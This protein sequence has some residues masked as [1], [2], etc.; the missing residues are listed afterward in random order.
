MVLEEI[1]K[2]REE[3]KTSSI[4][5]ESNE[6]LKP[7]DCVLVVANDERTC[8][9]LRQVGGACQTSFANLL[10]VLVSQY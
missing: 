9:Q 10:C 6:N 7:S 1:K 4:T 5:L 3:R 2:E 8:Y